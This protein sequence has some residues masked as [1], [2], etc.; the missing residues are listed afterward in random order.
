[1]KMRIR[2]TRNFIFQFNNFEV[3]ASWGGAKLVKYLDGRVELKG[4]SK[5]DQMEAKEW[6]SM[7]MHEV[8][9]GESTRQEGCAG[10]GGMRLRRVV[11]GRIPGI[12]S[13]NSI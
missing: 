2:R 9:V 11:S 7:F 10:C 13:G 8:V 5:E 6:I 12:D 4:G 3:I 1:M